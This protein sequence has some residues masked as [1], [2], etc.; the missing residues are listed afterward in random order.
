MKRRKTPLQC[1]LLWI[2][3]DTP[4]SNLFPLPG[5]DKRHEDP[6][7]I[8]E[9]GCSKFRVQ[10]F[11]LVFNSIF[12]GLS[13]KLL[14]KAKELGG[15]SGF[16]APFSFLAS[17]RRDR[18]CFT[19]MRPTQNPSTPP[20]PAGWRGSDQEPEGKHAR[21]L[22]SNKAA[23]VTRS[24]HS[25]AAWPCAS[26]ASQGLHVVCIHVAIRAASYRPETRTSYRLS[27]PGS[28][29]A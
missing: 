14:E 26:P 18:Q 6:P 12:A 21:P 25:P 9:M 5:F 7:F 11:R 8:W 16:R 19:S 28:C 22:P 4:L 3:R 17:V 29:L 13:T 23:S 20:T 10:L 24:R 2:S 27:P 15:T 1:E